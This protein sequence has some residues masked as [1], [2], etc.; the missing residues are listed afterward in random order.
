M[1]APKK[2]GRPRKEAAD[3]ATQKKRDYQRTYQEGRK[4]KMTELTA[5]IKECEDDLKKMKKER[6]ELRDMART[7]LDKIKADKR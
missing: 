4:E 7:K 3:T 1:E 5:K 6:K 2:R